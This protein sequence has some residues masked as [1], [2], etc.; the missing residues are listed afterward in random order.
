[1]NRRRAFV[2]C[3]GMIF[4]ENR[5]TLFR[6]IPYARCA[7]WRAARDGADERVALPHRISASASAKN[8]GQQQ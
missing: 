8:D 5:F 1:M 4:S 3:L 2:S 7:E 6:I